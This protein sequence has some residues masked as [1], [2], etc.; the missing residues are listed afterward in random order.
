MKE[1]KMAAIPSC[2]VC[3]SSDVN[4]VYDPVLLMKQRDNVPVIAYRC[5]NEHCFLPDAGKAA[6]AGE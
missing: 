1:S 5:H 3:G 6:G 4:P 2:P